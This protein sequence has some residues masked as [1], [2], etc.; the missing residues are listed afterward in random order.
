MEGLTERFELFV[1]HKEICN[2]YTEL[3]NPVIQRQ[4]FKAQAVDQASGDE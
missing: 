3:N 1:L 4:R 2:A